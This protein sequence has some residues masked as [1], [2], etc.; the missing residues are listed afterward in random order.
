M[1]RRALEASLES[2]S[3]TSPEP[4]TKE[5]PDGGAGNFAG[6]TDHLVAGFD[7]Q[8]FGHFAESGVASTLLKVTGKGESDVAVT[9]A[10]QERAVSTNPT[11]GPQGKGYQP[12]LGY[13]LE[14]RHHVQAVAFEPGITARLGGHAYP[15]V[16]GTLRKDAGDNQMAV[17]FAQNTRDEVRL[18]AGDG[19]IVGDLAAEPGMKQTSYVAIGTD[20]YNGAI[21]GDVAATMTK[22]SG[23]GTG[24]GPTPLALNHTQSMQVRRLTPEECERLQGFPVGHTRIPWRGKAPEDCPDGPRYKSLGNSMA[25]PCMAWIAKRIIRHLAGEI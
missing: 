14:A 24:S 12:D 1:L 16:S 15:D 19:S 7:V 2:E 20:M 6:Y 9:Y 22:T 3:Q 5:S 8:G 23:T 11:A 21:T 17:A 18:Q 4:S 25:V 10:I 13:T